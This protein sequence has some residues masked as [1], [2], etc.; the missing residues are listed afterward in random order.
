MFKIKLLGF[1]IIFSI[2]L[3]RVSFSFDDEPHELES[4]GLPSVRQS[5]ELEPL[6]ITKQKQ[7]LLNA[8]STD[9]VESSA[10]NYESA[11][12]SLSSLPADLQSRSLKSGIQTDFSLRGSTFQQVLILLNGQRINDPQTAHHN[13]DI[14]FTKEDIKKIEVF[15]GAG[16]SL[17]GPDAIG[18]AI[19]F[20]LA[21]PRERKIT[22]E[23]ASVII[24]TAMDYLA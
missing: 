4:S 20:A 18:G 9:L 13:A 11:I 17:F 19:N 6:V 15:P 10:F 7:F 5:H 3:P 12:E 23:F 1:F 2:I 21:A 8:Y 16:S 24:A 14:P 22:W